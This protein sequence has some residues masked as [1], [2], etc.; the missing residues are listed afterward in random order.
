MSSIRNTFFLQTF[1]V[2]GY[3]IA[4]AALAFI[5][6]SGFSAFHFFKNEEKEIAGKPAV[7]EMGEKRR[8]LEVYT[9]EKPA[10][11]L[12]AGEP[13]PLHIDEVWERL[14]Y[15]LHLNVYFHSNTIALIKR[16]Y[17]WL[18]EIAEVLKKYAIPDDF[19]YLPLIES[20]LQNVVSP[21]Q[22]VG[23]WQLRES[24][25]RELG[26]EVTKQV[27][28]RYDPI[29]ST[30]AASQ[31]L[32]KAYEKFGSW[33]LAAA[34][35]N[36]G[37]KGLSRTL[38]EQRVDS[39]YDLLLNEETARYIYR[40]LA[41]KEIL[42]RPAAYGYDIPKSH[43]Y[44]KASIRR[45]VVDEDIKDLAVFAKEQGVNYKVLK[46]FNPWLRD[47]ALNV[48]KGKSYEI[49]LPLD[50]EAYMAAPSL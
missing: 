47:R 36:M 34:A 8:P 46:K 27:D 16:S 19:K 10:E 42:N 49:Q 5:L 17:R 40:I 30:E 13:A 23:F 6:L 29:R 38:N 28:E 14:D 39:Y 43:M 32:L 25:A 21:R 31:Y 12:F 22:A 20:G 18:P 24:T 35:Y 44:Q 7:Y 4:A 26:L 37:I 11:A 45:I 33:T 3:A 15:E 9:F 41:I 2:K 48:R 50:V 1:K